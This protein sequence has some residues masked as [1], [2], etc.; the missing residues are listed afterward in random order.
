M[1]IVFNRILIL[2]QYNLAYVF[3]Y[4]NCL[5]SGKNYKNNICSDTM[6]FHE[7]GTKEKYDQMKTN[8]KSFILLLT[9]RL[10]FLE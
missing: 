10:R 5:F 6:L 1:K 8:N 2:F 3:T 7:N 9:S 4:I